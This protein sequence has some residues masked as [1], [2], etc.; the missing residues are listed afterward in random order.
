MAVKIHVL[1]KSDPQI[2]TDEELA[3]KDLEQWF[4]DDLKSYPQ[5]KGDIYILPN[6]FIFGQKRRD[7]DLLIFGFIEDLSINGTFCAKTK[8][9]SNIRINS[10]EVQSFVVNVELKSHPSNRVVREGNGHYFVTYSSTNTKEDASQQAHETMHSL[11]NH[12]MSQLDVSPFVCDVIWF[13]NLSVG[14]LDSR[15]PGKDNALPNKFSFMD[16]V[17][18][19]LLRADVFYHNGSYHLNTYPNGQKDF[20]KIR[21]LF[22]TK[23][24]AKG[25]TKQK[26]ELLSAESL[27]NLSQLSTS[28]GNQLTITT[29]RAGT[30]KTMQLLQLAFHLANEDNNKRCLLLTYNRALVSDIQRLIDFTPMPSKLDGRTVCIKTINSFFHSLME[31]TGAVTTKLNPNDP[32]YDMNYVN[33]LNELKKF[34]GEECEKNGVDA[35]KEVADQFIDWDYI[36]IDEAQ[37]CKDIEKEV[38]F[39]VYG[40]HR[41]VVADGVDQFV[42]GNKQQ[43]WDKGLEKG[44]FNKPKSMDL[45]RRQKTNLVRF[46]NAFAKLAGIDW[47]VKPNEDLPGGIIKIHKCYTVSLHNELCQCCKENGCENYD[48]LILEPPCMIEK[49]DN[50][51]HFKLA[52]KYDKA[53]IRM[54]DGTNYNNRTAYP[55]KDECRLYQYHSCRGLEGW[56]V[57]CDGLD[58]LFQHLVDNWRP[59]GDELGLDQGRMKESFAFLWTMM[60]LT[61]PIDT[62]VITLKDPNSKIG[63]MLKSLAETHRD[64]VEWHIDDKMNSHE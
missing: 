44:S 49:D 15:R 13:K 39:K 31:S 55:T 45:E 47:V 26:F 7:V 1:G 54:F 11:R 5:A 20:D 38:L 50:G 14:D 32:H 29:G 6:V 48:I 16:F 33:G 4:K 21:N 30:G 57:V 12:L 61:R 62:L 51:S 53:G 3:A 19:I 34:V 36:F 58:L 24:E 59:T 46:A 41:I 37:D 9:R 25:L 2:Q 52:N 40:S 35:L 28:I 10:L 17:S 22:S 56:C 63:K 43:F 60:P 8:D 18:T 27:G 42:S 23:R 64:Y